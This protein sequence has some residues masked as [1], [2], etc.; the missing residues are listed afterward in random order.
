MQWAAQQPGDFP[1]LV[2]ADVESYLAFQ[3]LEAGLSGNHIDGTADG[4][5][6]VE[7]ALRTA[8]YLDSLDIEHFRIDVGNPAQVDIVDEYGDRVV[9][10]G[11]VVV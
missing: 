10:A 4:V 5:L 6:A 8:Q 9:G 3:R 7:R 1:A 11:T 2:V